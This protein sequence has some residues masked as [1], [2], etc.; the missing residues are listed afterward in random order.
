[1]K[2]GVSRAPEAFE[3]GKPEVMSEAAP[4]AAAFN[5][6]NDVPQTEVNDACGEHNGNL[7]LTPV[8]Q[9]M[10]TKRKQWNPREVKARK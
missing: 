8:L 3:V 5:D 7:I 6:D 2:S 4:G 1:V 9:S 10:G